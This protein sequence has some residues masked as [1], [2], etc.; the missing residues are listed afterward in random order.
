MHLEM[1]YNYIFSYAFVD[2]LIERYS[3]SDLCDLKLK[4][5]HLMRLHVN[6]YIYLYVLKQTSFSVGM[7]R[8]QDFM[9]LVIIGNDP[10]N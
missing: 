4:K 9:F 5:S 2:P 8:S 10:C 3:K 1:A 7:C 6:R